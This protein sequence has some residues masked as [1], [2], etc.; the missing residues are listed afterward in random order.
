MMPT[1]NTSD[2]EKI[3]MTFIIWKDHRY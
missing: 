1:D 2:E 3:K